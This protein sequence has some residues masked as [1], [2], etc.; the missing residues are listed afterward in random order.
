MIERFAKD[1]KH[2]RKVL[3]GAIKL[4][5]RPRRESVV[6][7]PTTRTH[8]TI[9]SM[10]ERKRTAIINSKSFF[11]MLDL[12][13]DPQNIRKLLLRLNRPDNYLYGN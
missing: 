7:V 6:Y 2:Y 13:N 5:S 1:E 11:P 4:K 10:V 3:S 12:Y 8:R 9:Q